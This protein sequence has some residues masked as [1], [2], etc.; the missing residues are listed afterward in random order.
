MNNDGLAG[1]TRLLLVAMV[2][3]GFGAHPQ[4][5]LA[6]T[7]RIPRI[8]E[9]ALPAKCT[10]VILVLSP[11]QRSI[12]ARL[13]LI[14]RPSPTESWRTVSRPINVSLGRSGLAWGD[15]EHQAS[16]PGAFPI[17][18][19]GDGCSPA[20]VF[21]IPSAFGYAP[22]RDVSSLRL[23]YLAL[24]KTHFGIDDSESRHYNQVVDAQTVSKDWNRA[25]I[26]RRDDVLYRWGAMVAH[27]PRNQP[28]GGSC[29][30]LHIWKGPGQ[31][32]S[33]CTAMAE[34]DIRRLL[35]WLNPA[36]EPRLVQALESW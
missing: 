14:G 21:R 2:A 5:V 19:E 12:S 36:K 27:N 16:P 35:E 25:E 33:G 13:W 6:Q 31:P 4:P 11:D 29:I 20:G 34:P 3:A 26:M 9:P 10:Q 32:T 17:K 7:P 8:F 24:T 23:A 1:R 30:F 15:G 22:Q 18:R 28:R